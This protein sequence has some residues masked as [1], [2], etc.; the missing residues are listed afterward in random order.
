MVGGHIQIFPPGHM[1]ARQ[2]YQYIPRL[3]LEANTAR[4]EH[5]AC[6]VVTRHSFL[7]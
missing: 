3:R 5:S 6:L 1:K 7:V 4:S 2:A